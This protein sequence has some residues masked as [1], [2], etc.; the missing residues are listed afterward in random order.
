M[1]LIIA[2]SLVIVFA[3]ALSSDGVLPRVMLA[4]LADFPFKDRPSTNGAVFAAA[5]VVIA[6]CGVWLLSE[7]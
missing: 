6:E 5:L 7:G 1:Y 2:L 3:L 4:R